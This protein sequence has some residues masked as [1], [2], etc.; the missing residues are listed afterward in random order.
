MNYCPHCGKAVHTLPDK[1]YIEWFLFGIALPY[2][3]I[4]LYFWFNQSNKKAAKRLLQ[5]SLGSFAFIILG[6]TVI[7]L[8]AILVGVVG[9]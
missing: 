1:S 6:F 8:Y 4:I 5:G 7:I 2:I 3:G 9:R